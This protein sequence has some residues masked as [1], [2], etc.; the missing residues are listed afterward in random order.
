[1]TESR[2][3]S[4]CVLSFTTDEVRGTSVPVGVALWSSGPEWVNV[5]V[6]KE[7]DSIK[8]LN[9]NAYPFLQIAADKLD[10]WISENRLPYASTALRPFTDEWWRQVRRLLV[11]RV[12]ISEPRP[13]DCKQPDEELALLYEAVVGPRRG[14]RER[15]ERIDGVL[16]NS[17]GPV[18]EKLTRGAVEGFGGR[19]VPVRRYIETATE[20]LIVEGV[21]LAAAGAEIDADALVSRLLRIREANGHSRIRSVVAYVGYLASPEGLNGEAALVKWIETKAEAKTYDLLSQRDAFADQIRGRLRELEA[22]ARDRPH[23]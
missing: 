21:N 22:G 4:Y 5:R 17:L 3:F 12:R 14:A 16:T 18:A 15:R 6:A 10:K 11:H 2:S 13:I 9:R 19:P 8:G 20:L 23:L 1:M 7:E